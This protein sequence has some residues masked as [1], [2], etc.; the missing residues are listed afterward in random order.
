MLVPKGSAYFKD[1]LRAE[2]WY[3]EPGFEPLHG[4]PE[5]SQVKEHPFLYPNIV[6][7]SPTPSIELPLKDDV[8]RLP[9]N[10]CALN[11]I[12]KHSAEKKKSERQK[13]KYTPKSKYVQQFPLLTD[14]ADMR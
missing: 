14:L 5:P 12:K 7:P 9:S 6:S 4:D 10:E 13:A 1:D 3:F 11:A 8:C 2:R